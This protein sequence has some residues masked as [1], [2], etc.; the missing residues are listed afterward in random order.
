MARHSLAIKLGCR[1]KHSAS[2]VLLSNGA[3]CHRR[4]VL[5]A[6]VPSLHPHLSLLLAKQARDRSMLVMLPDTDIDFIKV[7]TLISR[8]DIVSARLIAVPVQRVA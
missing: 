2:C 3:I 6:L 5:I 1:E 4:Q 8:L 7:M